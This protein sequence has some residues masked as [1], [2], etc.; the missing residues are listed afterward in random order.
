MFL[1]IVFVTCPPARNAPANSKMA[2]IIIA[3][4]TLIA[5]DPT[6]VPIAFATSL[7]PIPQVI[8]SP[9]TTASVINTDPYSTINFS[10]I[11]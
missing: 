11:N 9:N 6:D 5:P 8:K 7:A 3:C 2:A 10:F 1:R 4:L